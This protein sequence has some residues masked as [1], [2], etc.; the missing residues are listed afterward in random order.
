MQ[1]HRVPAGWGFRW[2]REGLG[3]VRRGLLPLTMLTLAYLFVLMVLTLIPII[4]PAAPL[5]VVPSLSVGLMVAARETDQGANPTL[6]TLLAGL[7]NYGGA[8]RNRLLM[9]GLVNAAT[10]LVALAAAASADDGTLMKLATGAAES[11]DLEQVGSEV[12]WASAIF[13]ALYLPAQMGLWFA[14][15]FVSWHRMGIGQ[16]LFFSF[17]TVWRNRSAFSVFLF[18]WFCLAL[19]ASLLLQTIKTLAPDTPVL[20]SIVLTPLSLILMTGLYAS[21]WP[22]YR[23]SVNHDARPPP[24]ANGIAGIES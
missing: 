12:L 17:F 6:I 14:P 16:S 23:D 13:L 9:L 20:I 22:G 10:T 21:Y 2:I 24:T 4:G 18:G 3:L 7:R 19:L 5:V 15:L 1:V 11:S 8:A